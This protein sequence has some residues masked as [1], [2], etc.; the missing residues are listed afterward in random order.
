MN[1]W[2]REP[3]VFLVDDDDAVRRSL[4]LLIGTYGL[5]VES[6]A[7][8]ESFLKAW[9]SEAVGCLVLDIRMGGLSGLALQDLLRERDVPLPIV[10]ITGHGDIAA[11]RRA[12]RQGA[13]DFLTKP[14]DEHALM[15]AIRK[16]ISK[17]VERHRSQAE[18]SDLIQRLA[19]L[20]DRE[21]QVLKGMLQGLPNKL[22]ARDISLSSRTVESHRARLYTKLQANS[23][24]HL[25]RL[26]VKVE[27]DPTAADFLRPVEA[28]AS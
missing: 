3:T 22:I 8:A 10:F 25:I 13:V 18:S 21:R 19:S 28:E 12:F 14:V 5:H 27:D 1:P 20:S 26:I 2:L 11:C 15:Q 16:G 4:K 17:D 24:A 7:S 23:L 6:H 9:C